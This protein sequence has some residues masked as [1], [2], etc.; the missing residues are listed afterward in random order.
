MIAKDKSVEFVNKYFL[1]LAKLLTVSQCL[2]FFPLT[3]IEIKIFM[4]RHGRQKCLSFFRSK[5][6]GTL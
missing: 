6:T 2:L 5:F 3:G 4:W 1:F